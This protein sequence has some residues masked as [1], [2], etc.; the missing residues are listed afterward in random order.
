[1]TAFFLMKTIVVKG[2][3]DLYSKK[4]RFLVFMRILQIVQMKSINIWFTELS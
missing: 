1:M 4:R 3:I 2:V